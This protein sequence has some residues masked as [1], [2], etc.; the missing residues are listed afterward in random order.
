MKFIAAFIYSKHFLLA[1][2]VVKWPFNLILHE[3]RAKN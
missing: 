2:H 3:A 1:M